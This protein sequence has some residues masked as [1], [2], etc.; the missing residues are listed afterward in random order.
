MLA[1]AFLRLVCPP[2][3][4]RPFCAMW[5][6]LMAGVAV[7]DAR[8]EFQ[9]GICSHARVLHGMPADTVAES[10][11]YL[12]QRLKPGESIYVYDGQPI[13]YFMTR[14]VPPT[15]FAFPDT[16][17]NEE[18]A[19]RLGFTPQDAVKIILARKPRFIVA[20]GA[21]PVDAT[22]TSASTL[23]YDGLDRYYVPVRAAD[24][25]APPRHL[26]TGWRATRL[27]TGAQECALRHVR[28]VELDVVTAIS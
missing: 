7:I 24:V 25:N 21:R 19:G 18:V 27:S 12:A 23:L 26:R 10:G 22:V 15:R 3:R 4:L 11:E 5:M 1:A 13:L 6:V 17:L 20:G 8:E 28:C 2:G 14:S 16:H 9:R